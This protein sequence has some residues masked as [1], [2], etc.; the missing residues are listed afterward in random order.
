MQDGW[1]KT[2]QRDRLSARENIFFLHFGQF[3]KIIVQTAQ[4]RLEYHKNL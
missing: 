3:V 4:R 2:W 1:F